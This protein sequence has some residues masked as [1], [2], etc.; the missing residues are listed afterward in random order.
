MKASE[1]RFTGIW[2]GKV[3]EE[4]ARVR[5]VMFREGSARRAVRI[6]VPT[7]PVACFR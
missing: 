6:G 3:A 5:M 2:D 1:T 7:E 4:D